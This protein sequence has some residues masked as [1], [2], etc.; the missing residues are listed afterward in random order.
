MR[1]LAVLSILVLSLGCV[2]SKKAIHAKAAAD[3]QQGIEVIL[4]AGALSTD[5]SA[6]LRNVGEYSSVPEGWTGPIP[7]SSPAGTAGSSG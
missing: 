5:T 2:T 1:Y 6:T 7:R 4:E 3:G